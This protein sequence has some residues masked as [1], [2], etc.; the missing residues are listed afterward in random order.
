MTQIEL[1]YKETA[2]I[3]TPRHTTT[4]LRPA[5]TTSILGRALAI[6]SWPFT[7]R[8][9][10]PI[11]LLL[12][13]YVAW[14]FVT[15]G[16]AKIEG[17]FLISDP[18]GEMLKL[19][20]NGAIPVPFEFYR[21]V[22]GMLVGAGLTPLISHTMPFL[23]LAIALSLITGVLTPLAAFGALLLNVNF[24]LS[25]IGQIDFD[26][27]YMVAE[28]LMILGYSVVGVIGFEKLAL[29]ILKTVVAKVR[30]ARPEVA[31]ARR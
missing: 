25:G 20:A 15:M 12:R 4:T 21:G 16:I 30:P 8:H 2:M 27:P 28:V 23:E 9:A 31:P 3:T 17:G 1:R 22:A 13:L 29:R 7:N 24:V 10:A 26:F 6:I 18:I 5:N 19:V 11:W 14:V